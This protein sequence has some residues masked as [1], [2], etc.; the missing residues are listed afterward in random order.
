MGDDATTHR[1]D[2]VGVPVEEDLECPA[3]TVDGVGDEGAI[4][5]AARFD[6]FSYC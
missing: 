3:V 6:D 5:R 4:R 1:V 2:A